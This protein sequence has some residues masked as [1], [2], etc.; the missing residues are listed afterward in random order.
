MR[1]AIRYSV[2]AAAVLPFLGGPASATESHIKIRVSYKVI[3]NPADGNRPPG[4]SDEQIDRNL[5]SMNTILDTHK[6]GYRF[7][8]ADAIRSVGAA[9]DPNGPSKYYNDRYNTDEGS[10]PLYLDTQANP[11]AYGW[12]PGVINIY[13]NNWGGGC[14]STAIYGANYALVPLGPCLVNN[15]YGQLQSLL[16]TLYSVHPTH[17]G[18][19]LSCATPGQTGVC[20]TIP[21]DD[22]V[23]DTLPDLPAWNQDDISSYSFGVP[24][25]SLSPADRN[26]VDDTYFNIA[27]F[28][29]YFPCGKQMDTPRLTERQLDAWGDRIRTLSAFQEGAPFFVDRNANPAQASGSS[30]HPF[31]AVAV[32][33]ASSVARPGDFMYLR[34]GHYNERLTISKRL[35]LR[36]T[37]AGDVVIG[38]AN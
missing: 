27:S 2:M 23:A 25:A 13:I 5:A 12:S 8:R 22:F 19:C 26:R 16:R 15:P 21:G 20:F 32:A 4:T 30:G 18:G 3:V 17:G 9:G 24:Y 36:A 14:G 34:P 29:G 35:T 10:Y 6:R 11:F 28:H 7:V 37:R 33:A 31:A 1:A 38:A